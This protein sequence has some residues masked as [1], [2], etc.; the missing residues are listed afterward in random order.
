MKKR[1]IKPF[2]LFS[3]LWL[4]PVWFLPGYDYRYYWES[5]LDN[6]DILLS[7]FSFMIMVVF[8][9]LIKNP[10]VTLSFSVVLSALFVCFDC[11]F[12]FNM[13]SLFLLVLA[14][15]ECSY[16]NI[17]SKGKKYEFNKPLFYYLIICFCLILISFILSYNDLKVDR[18]IYI[19]QSIS[20][21]ALTWL[22]PLMFICLFVS[23]FLKKP[24]DKNQVINLRI[25]YIL[26]FL[27]FVVSMLSYIKASAFVIN[28]R[29]VSFPWFLYLFLLIVNKDPYFS[30]FFQALD[31]LLNKIIKYKQV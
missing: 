2:L 19:Y 30:V 26:S 8:L 16:N 18:Y 24:S 5:Y 6:V 9:Y 23:T 10:Y 13:L 20:Y 25:V 29:I 21:V 14:H 31:N 22:I 4:V 17:K 28:I 15:K 12:T 11:H 7:I 3:A 1:T 27:R